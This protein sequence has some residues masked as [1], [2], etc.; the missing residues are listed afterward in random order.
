MI[1]P[2]S[3]ILNQR[4]VSESPR[5][6]FKILPVPRENDSL[7]LV[8]PQVPIFLKNSYLNKVSKYFGILM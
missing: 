6:H 2:M 3:V 1:T 8:R 7:S 4:E 5:E